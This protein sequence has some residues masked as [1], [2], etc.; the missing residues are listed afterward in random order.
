VCVCLSLSLFLSLCLSV[1]VSLSFSLCVCIFEKERKKERKKKD[2]H[3]CM[4]V[5]FTGIAGGTILY[6]VVF[7]ILEREKKKSVP[8]LLQLTFLLIGF[9]V[10]VC[11]EV[12]GESIKKNISK[13]QYDPEEG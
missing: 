3:I 12:F 5:V 8:G 7:E 2:L 11:I 10:M 1:C 9:A 13:L 4:S 6:V